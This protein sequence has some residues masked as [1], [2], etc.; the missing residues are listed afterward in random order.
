MTVVQ[1]SV[2]DCRGYDGIAEHRTP[3]TDAEITV[4]DQLPTTT[5]VSGRVPRTLSHYIIKLT[6]LGGYL[7]RIGDL[8]PGNIV[9][10]R[11]LTRLTDIVLRIQ[12]IAKAVGS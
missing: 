11:G 5:A 7:A 12:L 8:P 6:K 10:R 4:L 3:F 2:Q 9:M 1:H